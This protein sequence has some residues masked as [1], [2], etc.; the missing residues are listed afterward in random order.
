MFNLLK[1]SRF[2]HHRVDNQ[3]MVML[4]WPNSSRVSLGKGILW[5]FVRRI[6]GVKTRKIYAD[7]SLALFVGRD[8]W[9]AIISGLAK[10]W[11]KA[12]NHISTLRD[13]IISQR[14]P[15]LS[16][17]FFRSVESWELIL[18]WKSSRTADIDRNMFSCVIYNPDQ[19]VEWLECCMIISV[20]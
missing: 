4:H 16:R 11:T 18:S 7:L 5:H 8:G 2:R 14:W 6:G 13:A 10:S 12:N 3:P 19:C 20:R 1:N 15:S 9:L 17:L